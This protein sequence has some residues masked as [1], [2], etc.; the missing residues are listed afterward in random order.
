[1]ANN[2]VILQERMSEGIASERAS[3]IIKA[4]AEHAIDPSTKRFVRARA[5]RIDGWQR[6]QKL[7][8]EQAAALAAV[9]RTTVAR[10]PRAPRA[11]PIAAG[12]I[13]GGQN[14]QSVPQGTPGIVVDQQST[15][16][17]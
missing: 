13:S 10:K 6:L 14:V 1:M 7:A 3:A 4:L 16:V 11:V 15:L 9:A 5:A 8:G 2:T 17:S 12:H